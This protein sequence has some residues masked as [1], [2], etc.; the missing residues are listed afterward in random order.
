MVDVLPLGNGIIPLFKLGPTFHWSFHVNLVWKYGS[1]LD[2]LYS[3]RSDLE[4]SVGVV[5]NTVHVKCKT[6]TEGWDLKKGHPRPVEG[7]TKSCYW[8]RNWNCSGNEV[9][10]LNHKLTLWP[11]DSQWLP[12]TRNKLDVPQNF[13]KL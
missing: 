9:Q 4:E 11:S 6:W 1:I 7:D 12:E 3:T 10:D 8:D 5:D 2:G 13:Y